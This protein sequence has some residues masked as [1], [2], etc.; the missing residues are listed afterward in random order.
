MPSGQEA[1]SKVWFVEAYANA[2]HT[3]CPKAL[4]AIHLPEEGA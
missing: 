2:S 4:D 3:T 1:Q